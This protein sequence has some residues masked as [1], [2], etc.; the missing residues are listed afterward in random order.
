MKRNKVFIMNKD[1][2]VAEL[3]D[4]NCFHRI[5]KD[6]EAPIDLFGWEG[7]EREVVDESLFQNWM[8]SRTFPPERC[9]CKE[10]L[11]EMGLDRY[12]ALSQAIITKGVMAQDSFWIKGI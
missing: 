9:G 11:E 2:P 10:L 8:K 3:R 4:D 7:N 12:D 5:N 1:I 6:I